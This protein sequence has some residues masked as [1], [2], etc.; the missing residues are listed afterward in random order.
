MKN[1]LS[2]GLILIL[3]IGISLF[4]YE[5]A[6]KIKIENDMIEAINEFDERSKIW[7]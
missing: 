3:G 6:N 4:T 2:I 1:V 7:D 5:N